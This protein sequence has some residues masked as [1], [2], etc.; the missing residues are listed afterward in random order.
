MG[1][2]EW[3]HPGWLTEQFER[4]VELSGLL[5]IRLQDLRHVAASLMLDVDVEIVSEA[6]GHSDSRITRDIYQSVMPEAAR[7]AAEATVAMAPRRTT[8][9]VQ[10]VPDPVEPE[11]EQV[12][13]QTDGHA[14]GTQ[15]GAKI[16]AF[17]PRLV[18]AQ[19]KAL[20]RCYMTRASLEPPSGFEPETYALRVVRS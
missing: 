9:P 11:V 10:A 6:L 8:R 16:I 17:R 3:L 1:I 2:G 20:V 7:D 14:M 13:G 15:E 12:Q 4:L 5:P 18:R 19:E